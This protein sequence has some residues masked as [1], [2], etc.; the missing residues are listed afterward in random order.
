MKGVLLVWLVGFGFCMQLQAERVPKVI[1][2]RG[3]WKKENSAQ[4]SVAALREAGK[5]ACYG[6]EFDVQLS[7]DGRLV[8]VHDPVVEGLVIGEKPYEELKKIRLTNGET[9]PTLEEYLK[10]AKKIGKTRLILEIKPL[11]TPE[12]EREAVKKATDMIKAFRLDKKTEYISFS[13]NVLKEILRLVPEAF[14]AYLGSDLS[15]RE[16]KA[17]GCTGVDYNYEAVRQNP[18]WVDEAHRL[19]MTVNV[20][21]VDN[22]NV[23]R[24]MIEKGVDFITTNEPVLLQQIL[25]KK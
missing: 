9:I 25:R 16:I 19:G 22:E 24:E 1:A 12:K 4:N 11:S 20:W 18:D 7:G 6:S 14:T 5:V 10:T 2:H 21:T 23:M 3:Y 17:M 13:K 8:V 15:P